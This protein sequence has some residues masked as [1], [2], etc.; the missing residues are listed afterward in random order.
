MKIFNRIFK[1]TKNY[2]QKLYKMLKISL[3]PTPSTYSLENIQCC[4]VL[5]IESINCNVIVINITRQ[6]NR[7]CN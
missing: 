2:M 1:G 4:G 7:N 5:K 3:I 6:S